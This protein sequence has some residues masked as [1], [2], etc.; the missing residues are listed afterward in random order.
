MIPPRIRQMAD[1]LVDHIN[2]I[3]ERAAA[4]RDREP[5]F[6]TRSTLICELIEA[7]HKDRFSEHA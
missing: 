1:R 6:I 5:L 3:S 2:A 4:E 7:E